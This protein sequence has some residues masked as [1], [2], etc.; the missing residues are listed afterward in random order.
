MKYGPW[1]ARAIRLIEDQ[2]ELIKNNSLQ[3][4]IS[5]HFA[6]KDLKHLYKEKANKAEWRLD[7]WGPVTKSSFLVKVRNCCPEVDPLVAWDNLHLCRRPKNPNFYQLAGLLAYGPHALGK[8]QIC[9][10]DGR[11]DCSVVDAL[12]KHDKSAKAN[13]YLSWVWHY[14]LDTVVSALAEWW[15]RFCAR[16]G[17]RAG[18][19]QTCYLWWDLFV[20]NQFRLLQDG[21]E[22]PVEDWFA[23]LGSQLT[24]IGKMIVCM[25]RIRNSSIQRIWNMF[26]V[27]VAIQRDIQITL[28]I[29]P[30]ALDSAGGRLDSWRV[31]SEYAIRH[32]E[33]YIKRKILEQAGTFRHLDETVNQ[34]LVPEIVHLLKSTHEGPEFAV[35]EAHEAE[36][37]RYFGVSLDFVL[38]EF[39]CLY[40]N[41]ASEAEWRLHDNCEVTESGFIVKVRDCCDVESGVVAWDSL[42]V[43]SPPEN[44]NFYQLAGLLAYGPHALGKGQICPRDGRADC[45]LVDALAK[46][47]KSDNANW[48]LSWAWSYSLNVVCNALARWWDSHAAVVTSE[49]CPT[50]SVYLWWCFFVNN[51]FRMLEDGI[52][53]DTDSLLKVFA[54]PLQRAGKVLM[55]MDNFHNCTY[56]NR[57]WCIFEIFSAV[58]RNIPVTL[59]MPQLELE[60]EM[61]TLTEMV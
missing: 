4:G 20:N 31:D 55:C 52:T 48:F 60:Q 41:M 6:L 39:K 37:S 36:D 27:Y 19:G 57:I 32:Q 2:K 17:W 54:E 49:V 22:Y 40:R 16:T 44:P 21:S 28:A 35:E 53:Q 18:S 43:C 58:R 11:A 50:G 30:Q 9:P 46:K 51:Q 25:D 10:R 8:G 7:T 29:P 34:F 47:N 26:E 13:W 24:G 56:T 15:R 23:H 42:D 38:S 61:E 3:L 12:F 45:S 1:Q 33:L 59:I 5:L 14:E